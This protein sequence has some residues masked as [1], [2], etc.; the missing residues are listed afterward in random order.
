MDE[1][2]ERSIRDTF[3]QLVITGVVHPVPAHVGNLESGLR[4]KAY[5][6]AGDDIEAMVNPELLADGHEKLHT[7][8]DPQEGLPPLDRTHYRGHQ[9]SLGEVGHAVPEASYAG[10]DHGIGRLHRSRIARNNGAD[11]CLLQSFLG[12]SQVTHSIIH[13][14][15]SG[16]V[17]NGR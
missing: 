15:Y 11:P 16:A 6:P 13:N 8:T 9:T 2:E 7:Q 17:G 3:K 5:D 12:A 14:D 1:I 4:I 10:K